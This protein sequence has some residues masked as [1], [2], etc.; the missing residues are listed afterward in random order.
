VGCVAGGWIG[1]RYGL[2]K[3]MALGYV[4]TAL[5]TLYMAWLIATIGLT[6]IPLVTFFATIILHGF[7]Y[8]I[9]FGLRAALLM[10][11]TNKAVAATQ[12]TAFMAMGNLAISIA[13]YWQGVV[14][15]RF[16]YSLA[17]YLD[18]ALI[19]IPVLLLPFVRSGAAGIPVREAAEVPA[20]N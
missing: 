4:L 8:G 9:G 15:E 19:L 11:M 12:F 17:L 16:D 6:A 13:N 5:P 10:G 1:D 2:R 3:C 20:I 18:A 7:F 14:A